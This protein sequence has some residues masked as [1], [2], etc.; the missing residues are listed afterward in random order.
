MSICLIKPKIMPMLSSCAIIEDANTNS[1]AIIGDI[2][3]NITLL[4][5]NKF[6]DFCDRLDLVISD[7]KILSHY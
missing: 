3:P 6:S 7:V 5:G 1:I 4:F 2:N